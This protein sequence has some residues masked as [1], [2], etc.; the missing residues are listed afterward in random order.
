M[1]PGGRC[2]N[3]KFTGCTGKKLPLGVIALL[4][5][6]TT[7][8]ACS[9][10]ERPASLT[11]EAAQPTG[12]SK[13]AAA[14]RSGTGVLTGRVPPASGGLPSVVMLEPETRGGIP[15]DVAVPEEPA[16]IDQWGM[17]FVPEVLVV[18]SGQTVE[19]HNSED[20]LHNV[21]VVD[22]E[23]TSTVTN[24]ATPT[25]DSTFQL[26]FEHPGTYQVL[27]DVHAAMG[28]FIIVTSSPYS[29]VAEKDGTFALP[30]VPY[31]SYT[32]TVWNLD[33]SRQSRQVVTVAGPR[34]EVIVGENR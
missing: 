1:L 7:A 31:G 22:R 23:T 9:S 19:F 17:A 16:I 32:L 3:A 25:V 15:E 12:T 29:I 33:E 21:H 14:P 30:E 24:V 11:E 28:A 5:S 20:V 6:C 10:A 18:R 2:V 27:C 13:T 26:V 34:T 8:A 4:F